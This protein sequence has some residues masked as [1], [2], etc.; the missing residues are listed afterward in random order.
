MCSKINLLCVIIVVAWLLIS[1]VY[2]ASIKELLIK[3]NPMRFVTS[4]RGKPSLN[5]ELMMEL[6]ENGLSKIVTL[7]S[8]DYAKHF[9]GV[10]DK[11]KVKVTCVYT[12]VPSMIP[13]AYE[14]LKQ[15]ISISPNVMKGR[16]YVAYSIYDFPVTGM[17][18][19]ATPKICAKSFGNFINEL[20]MTRDDFKRSDMGRKAIGQIVDAINYL[21]AVDLAYYLSKENVCFDAQNNL[22]LVYFASTIPLLLLHKINEEEISIL[23]DYDMQTHETLFAIYSLLI[24]GRDSMFISNSLRY[25]PGPLAYI[26]KW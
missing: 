20:I 12:N 14:R 26:R 17:H 21:R 16:D 13:Y 15:P 25:A 2:G 18:C 4:N 19:Y 10:L 3:A 24:D 1:T 22:R 9:M 11:R 5:T 23:K 7:K 8:S 6:E